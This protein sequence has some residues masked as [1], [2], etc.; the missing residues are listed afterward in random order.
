MF[1]GFIGLGSMGSAMASRLVAAGHRV[2]VW[3]RTPRTLDGAESAASLPAIAEADVVISMLADDRAVRATFH[4]LLPALRNGTIH[5]NMATVSVELAR[6][7]APLHEERG[8]TYLAAP[9]LGR[10]DAAA[11]GRLHIFAAGSSDAI[12][13][14]QP[15][16]DVLGQKTWRFGEKPEQANIVKIATNF[17]LAC[18]I[19]AMS[20]GAQ[21]VSSHD[22]SPKVFLEMLTGTLFAA[23]AYKTYSSLIAE[24]RFS[25]AGFNVTLGLK[26]VRLAL[27]AG[28]AAH[29]PLPFAS[30]LRDN[31]LDAI[32]HGE[33]DLDWSALARVARRRAGSL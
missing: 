6:E 23:P 29:V 18:A 5:V 20:E 3:N 17:T 33:A 4:D 15:L 11:A 25:P 7:L 28:E 21:F 13:T 26:D 27:A 31:F 19:E 30:I 8:V 9:V 14:V 32:A 1:I 22:V 12:V 2:R 10:P 16:F 24:E